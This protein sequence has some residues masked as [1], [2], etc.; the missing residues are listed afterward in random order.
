M[1]MGISLGAATLKR[2]DMTSM[3]N[4]KAKT[5]EYSV[6][7]GESIESSE[8]RPY[9]VDSTVRKSYNLLIPI[10]EPRVQC[11]IHGRWMSEENFAF[12]CKCS[13]NRTC[14]EKKFE[15]AGK[16]RRPETCFF[17]SPI[18]A[19]SIETCAPGRRHR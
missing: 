12:M 2:R 15:Q 16:I 10:A 9:Q 3:C 6:F 13:K 11:M 14:T 5:D 19:G 18:A 8:T 7:F 1:G 17:I 4:S